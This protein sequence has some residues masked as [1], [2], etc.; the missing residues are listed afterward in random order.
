M[1]QVLHVRRSNGIAQGELKI[2][3]LREDPRD[4]KV[5]T[6]TIGGSS[7]VAADI[8]NLGAFGVDTIA[9]S[10]AIDVAGIVADF[11]ALLASLRLTG[12]IN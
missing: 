1:G 12:I 6:L 11:N 5:A 4:A 7:V 8:A 2:E 10:T 9:D 3:D